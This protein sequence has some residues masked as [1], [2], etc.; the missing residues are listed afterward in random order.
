MP[1]PEQRRSAMARLRAE[2]AARGE[3]RQCGAPAS[4]FR[5]DECRAD[6]KLSNPEPTPEQLAA[7][8][9]RMRRLRA[10]R[11]GRHAA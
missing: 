8:R 6:H 2:R 9:E 7:Q 11:S 3:C 5:C 4:A 1:T 10:E